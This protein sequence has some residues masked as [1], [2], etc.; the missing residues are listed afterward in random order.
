MKKFL[1]YFIGTS[2]SGKTT[3]ASALEKIDLDVLMI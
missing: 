2:G 1:L 3:I